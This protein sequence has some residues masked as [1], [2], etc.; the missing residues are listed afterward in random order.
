MI[1][2][3]RKKK[4][5]GGWR[6]CPYGQI[7]LEKTRLKKKKIALHRTFQSHSYA[8]GQWETLRR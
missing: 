4:K 7:N 1:L 8:N 3:F 2:K 6:G 5:G